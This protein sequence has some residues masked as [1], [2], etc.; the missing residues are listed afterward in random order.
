MIIAETLI[1]I[2]VAASQIIYYYIVRSTPLQSVFKTAYLFL[3]LG[4]AFV[5]CSS[6]LIFP[7]SFLCSAVSFGFT[8]LCHFGGSA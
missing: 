8:A 4:N 3:R 6:W 1:F 2:G 5:R 7:N